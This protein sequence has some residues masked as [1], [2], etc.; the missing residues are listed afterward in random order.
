[1][2]EKRNINNNIIINS[3]FKKHNDIVMDNVPFIKSALKII[4]M[5]KKMQGPR[6]KQITSNVLLLKDQQ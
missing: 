3:S 4:T 2:L 1:M 6:L 5:H